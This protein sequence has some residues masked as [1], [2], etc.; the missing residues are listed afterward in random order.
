MKRGIASQVGSAAALAADLSWKDIVDRGYVI[1]GSA[2]TV[3]DRLDEVVDGL[4]VGHLMC[5]C[6][7]GNLGREAAKENTARFA[8]D[9]IPKLRDKFGDW[10]DKWWPRNRVEPLATP[11]PVE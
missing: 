11:A 6:Q 9:V 3:A 4:N 5:L 7:Y 10:E 8:S 2:Q 1:A